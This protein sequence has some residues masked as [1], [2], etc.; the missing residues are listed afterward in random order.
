MEAVDSGSQFRRSHDSGPDS[1]LYFL[2][3]SVR[4]GH[5]REAIRS[6][7]GHG[8][9]VKKKPPRAQIRSKNIVKMVHNIS[10][11][12]HRIDLIA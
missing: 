9:T 3:Q 4:A 11:M 6:L 1:R 12:K 5:C 10:L 2:G 7:P 8:Q